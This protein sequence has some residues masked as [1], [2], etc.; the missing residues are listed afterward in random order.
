MTQFMFFSA[1]TE[2]WLVMLSDQKLS[3]ECLA[4]AI[5]LIVLLPV[6]L[7]ATLVDQR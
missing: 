7:L 4:D 6:F 2:W 1:A 3:W 5:H